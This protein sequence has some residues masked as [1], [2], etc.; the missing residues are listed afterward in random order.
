MRFDP[1]PST[2]FFCGTI[3][4]NG[5]RFALML[6]DGDRQTFTIQALRTTIDHLRADGRDTTA[7]RRGYNQLRRESR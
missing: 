7:Y 2:P 6:I 5:K 3:D 1:T 4:R